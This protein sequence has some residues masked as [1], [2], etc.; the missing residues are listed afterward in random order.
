MRTM[1]KC[2]TPYPRDKVRKN[3]PK[4]IVIVEKAR[5]GDFLEYDEN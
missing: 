3:E 2:P 5:L 4:L 1:L